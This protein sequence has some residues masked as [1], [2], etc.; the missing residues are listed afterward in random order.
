M[1]SYWSQK[2][3]EIFNKKIELNFEFKPR[4]F[5][6][7]KKSADRPHRY[8]YVVVIV[9][10]VQV[11]SIRTIRRFP[12]GLTNRV[13]NF[14]NMFTINSFPNLAKFNH[15]W[16]AF[17]PQSTTVNLIKYNCKTQPR[18]GSFTI[19]LWSK[20]AIFGN[21]WFIFE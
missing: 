16:T 4:K 3:V 20:I 10:T 5:L 15:F 12:G 7:V 6:F 1:W 14:I 8:C 11:L 18:F 2:R 13:R 21:F 19:R 9:Y 17:E